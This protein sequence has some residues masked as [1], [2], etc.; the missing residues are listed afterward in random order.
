[1]ID[2]CVCSDSL[3]ACSS[4]TA[5]TGTCCA[6]SGLVKTSAAIAALR[7]FSVRSTI[8]SSSRT[9]SAWTPGAR[10]SAARG[11]LVAHPLP[12]LIIGAVHRVIPRLLRSRQQLADFGAGL[13]PPNFDCRPDLLEERLHRLPELLPE[14]IHHGH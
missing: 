2:G 9:L 10:S 5:V 3:I 13:R 12:L 14:W 6:V 1:M 8:K 7:S 4:V 11:A